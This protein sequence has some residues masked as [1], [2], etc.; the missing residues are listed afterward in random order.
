MKDFGFVMGNGI[1]PTSKAS[2]INTRYKDWW[3]VPGHRQHTGVITM[4]EKI[5]SSNT[6][7]K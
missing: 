3:Y 7:E 6:W 2:A 4:Y 1:F 5:D